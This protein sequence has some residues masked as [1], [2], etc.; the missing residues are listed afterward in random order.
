MIFG[1]GACFGITIA[2]SFFSPFLSLPYPANPDSSGNYAGLSAYPTDTAENEENSD[3]RLVDTT[4]TIPLLDFSKAGLQ[5]ALRS[6]IRAYKLSA[7]I[8]STVS[9][10]ISM[11]LENV[12]LNDALLF[13]FK[14][15]NL[16]WERTGD[17]LKIYR[18]ATDETS[19]LDIKFENGKISLA[20]E[21]EPLRNFVD[22]VI[23]LTGRNIIMNDGVQGTLTGRLTGID[24][25]EGLRAL[26]NSNGF[27]FSPVNG[28]YYVDFRYKPGDR[29]DRKQRFSVYCR[30][31]L[32]TVEA[33]NVPII[34]I[35]ATLS[36]NC[37][38]GMVIHTKI[39]G[40]TTVN[41]KNRPLDIL[42]G[43]I[44]MGT[45]YSF[46]KSGDIFV[47]GDKAS[48]DFITTRLIRLEHITSQ[49]LK[50]LI[51]APLAKQVTITPVMEQNGVAVTGAAT[52][53]LEI[54]NFISDI[55]LP[56]PQV[57][58]EAVVVD[59]NLSEMSEFKLDMDNTAL[60]RDGLPV[61]VYYPNIDYSGTGDRLNDHMANL[62][63]FL[64]IKNI[65][66]LAHDFFLRLRIMEEKGVA[67]IHSRPR[68]AAL[69][70]HSASIEIGTSQYFLL[71]SQTIY[72]SQQTSV[73]TQ[74]SQRFEV[75]KADMRLE[76]T[77][78]VTK[79]G[80]IIVQIQPE[81]NSPAADFNPDVPP[82]INRRVLKSTV[83][84]RD[85]ETII[86]GGM[87]QYNEQA[88]IAKF[89]LLG[90]LPLIGRIFQ[91]RKTSKTKSELMVYL[92]PHIYFGS[93]GSVEIKEAPGK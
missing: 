70:G 34:D 42:M 31:E 9:G 64:N 38:F 52:P 10:T 19:P 48:E 1:L 5:D 30:D 3:L 27:E 58:F 68:I 4:I 44:L 39:E 20:V 60:M 72:P 46:K 54:E 8:D 26:M 57:L 49:S 21:N 73:S 86:L 85:G 56:P 82:T 74:T 41:C 37:G 75:I 88:T 77:P 93:E 53:I 78:W 23:S 92:T 67:N 17:I 81:F 35:L 89:P 59:Y 76:V 69:N 71:E 22:T 79:S 66:H 16:A 11:R 84:L 43:H 6:I 61:H 62:A 45:S 90:S 91:N 29:N 14:E 80:E 2:L 50:D 51:P 55:D 32:V 15:Y 7:Y 40:A 63:D 87:I 28:I 24:F 36:E 65:G 18:P 33:V 25:D 83:R 13:I 47:I 12:S